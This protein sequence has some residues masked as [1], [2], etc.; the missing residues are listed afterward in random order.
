MFIYS[1]TVSHSDNPNDKKKYP[2]SRWERHNAK[3]DAK[4]RVFTKDNEMKSREQIVRERMRLELIK[5]REK[6]N[7]QLKDANRKRAAKKQQKS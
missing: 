7:R 2:N 6:A 5:S 4:K 1:R 3:L